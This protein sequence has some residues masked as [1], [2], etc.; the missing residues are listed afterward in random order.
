MI[1]VLAFAW[2]STLP[3]L[4]LTALSVVR[5]QSR[6]SYG[7]LPGPLILMR[8]AGYGNLPGPIILLIISVLALVG[9]G[10]FELALGNWIP[11]LP[12]GAFRILA[13]PLSALMLA[14]LGFVA[15]LV[16]I[17]S[18]GYMADDPDKTRF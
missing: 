15:T 14:I 12:D 5:T 10:S 17:Y 2:V 11:F 13:D 8:S 18:I 16:Y 6:A 9:G 3:S 1:Q 7:N 4:V